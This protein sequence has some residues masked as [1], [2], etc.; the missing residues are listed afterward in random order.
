MTLTVLVLQREMYDQLHVEMRSNH[1]SVASEVRLLDREQLVR[2]PAPDKWSVGEV[3]EHLVLMDELFLSATEPL[4]RAAHPDAGAP[5]RPFRESFVGKRIAGAL[6]APKAL[7]A[8]KVA[9]PGTPRAGVA[10]AFLAGD[11]RFLEL[12]E[13]AR[14]LDWNAVR[15]RPPVAPWMPMRI[16]LGDVFHIHTVHVRRHLAQIRRVKATQ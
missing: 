7:T 13:T 9:T 1:E 15:L 16:N 6:V 10:E 3:L 5:N 2:R 14:T 8:P 11:S 12:I 4:I